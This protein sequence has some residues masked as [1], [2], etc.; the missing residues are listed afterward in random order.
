MNSSL[1]SRRFPNFAWAWPDGGRLQLLQAA[2]NPDETVARQALSDWL[3]QNDLDDAS[4]PEHRLFAAITSRFGRAIDAL[5]EYPRLVGMHRL[6]WTQS[7]L[8]VSAN[9]P[10]LQK[11]VEMGLKPVLLK[12]A[13]RVALD[14]TQQKSRSAF[15]LDLVMPDAD[16]ETAAA[17]L[18]DDGW[19]STRGESA[20][21]LKARLSSVRARNFKKGRFGD[22]DLHRCAYQHIQA[23][24][25][26][27]TALIRDAIP[28]NYYDLP[29]FVPC[30]EERL[31]MAMGHGAWDGH[32]HSDWLV[33]IVGILNS[34]T[35]D[36]DKLYAIAQGRRL[37]GPVA[38][39]LSFLA[40]ELDIPLPDDALRRFGAHS[41]RAR[42]RDIPSLILARDA[43]DLTALQTRARAIVHAAARM[44]FSGRNAQSDTRQLRRLTRKAQAA[45][46]G[47]MVLSHVAAQSHSGAAGTWTLTANLV[48]KMPAIRRRIE[49]EINGADRNLGHVQVLHL[50]KAAGPYSVRFS[51]D[52]ALEET[53][54]PI[55]LVSL[56]SKFIQSEPDTPARIKYERLPFA[57]HLLELR[58]G[59]NPG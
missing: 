59:K 39:A 57:P 49:L 42:L 3:S 16:F 55:S 24:P 26:F 10:P 30:V 25:Q 50:S 48:F 22:I 23:H 11:F 8:A 51:M 29:V 54:F 21:G 47:P 35:V 53:D 45:D 40:Q 20:L 15:D 34:E 32:H 27:D 12:G 18:L 38:I 14:P 19:Q 4:F 7:R 36:W 46:T 44:R 17:M 52:L 13:A 31:V 28:V 41:A 58:Q 6:H 33:D 9:L 2:L 5:P 1:L 56:D 37:R 43:Q